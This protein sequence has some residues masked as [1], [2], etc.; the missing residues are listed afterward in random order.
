MQMHDMLSQSFEQAPNNTLSGLEE[1]LVSELGTPL[2][3]L[4]SAEPSRP[5]P[6]AVNKLV[7]SAPERGFLDLIQTPQKLLSFCSKRQ[8]SSSPTI[9]LLQRLLEYAR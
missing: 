1:K 6:V 3:P 2:T 8:P 5:S 4:I 7:L 9:L